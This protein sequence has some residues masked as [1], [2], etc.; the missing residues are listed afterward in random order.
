M[1]S[2]W[3]LFGFWQ[4]EFRE[5]HTRCPQKRKYRRWHF[6]PILTDIIC[7]LISGKL[8]NIRFHERHFNGYGIHIHRDAQT[9]VEKLLA[10]FRNVSFRR[11]REN[12]IIT[13]FFLRDTVTNACLW[14]MLFGLAPVVE[15]SAVR[16]AKSALWQVMTFQLPLTRR[17][18]RFP[19][20]QN[21]R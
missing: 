14:K 7:Q 10:A 15:A 16:D 5:L 8:S 19:A 20:Q 9:D 4:A 6:C 17:E 1:T 2:V 11:G 3:A 18:F 12:H 21:G 13:L